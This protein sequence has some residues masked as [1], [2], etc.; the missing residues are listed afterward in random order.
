[1]FNMLNYKTKIYK[2][3]KNSLCRKCGDKNDSK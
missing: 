2:W 3:N 1:M